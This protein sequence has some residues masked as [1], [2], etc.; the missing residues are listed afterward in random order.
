MIVTATA[1][2]SPTGPCGP[3]P[4]RKREASGLPLALWGQRVRFQ[5][6]PSGQRT[7]FTLLRFGPGLELPFDDPAAGAGAL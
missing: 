2:S 6:Q 3:W 4:C 7:I 5:E 1:V